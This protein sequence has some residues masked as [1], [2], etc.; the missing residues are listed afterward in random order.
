MVTG[1]FD[2]YRMV[3]D[4]CQERNRFAA[5]SK[6]ALNAVG[7]EHKRWIRFPESSEPECAE[8]IGRLLDGRLDGYGVHSVILSDRVR[9]ETLKYREG[10]TARRRWVPSETRPTFQL[11]LDVSTR[12][13][14]NVYQIT[15]S[16]SRTS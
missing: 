14:K 5:I 7:R 6:S 13:P 9:N 11:H 2:L 12:A 3:L 10:F 4:L 1:C 15:M 8:E 16:A